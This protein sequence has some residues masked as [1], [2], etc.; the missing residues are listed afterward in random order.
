MHICLV[1]SSLAAG[2]AERVVAT[3][4]STWVGQSDG[5]QVSVVTGDSGNEPAYALASSVKHIALNLQSSSVGILSA[6]RA[7]KYR[8]RALRSALTD[9]KPDCVVAFMDE[10]A[11]LV[12]VASLGTNVP[13]I[14]ALRS[15]PRGPHLNSIWRWMRRPFFQYGCA[16]VVVQTGS[17]YRIAQMLFPRA[18]LYIIPN[19]LPQL[20]QPPPMSER[21]RLVVSVGRLVSTKGLDDL[22]TAFSRS[23]GPMENWRLHIYGEGPERTRLEQQ[24]K[25]L[26]V[27]NAV[28][29]MGTTDKIFDHLAEASVFAFASR[30]E[31]FPNGLFE[32]AAMG[33]ACV[34]T[35]CE[36]GP[37]DILGEHMRGLL[38]PTNDIGALTNAINQLIGNLRLRQDLSQRA[39]ELR[40]THRAETIA[41]RWLR[42][43]Q[44]CAAA[45]EGVY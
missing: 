8:I 7:T 37:R 6:L 3:L 35:D 28:Q 12:S 9:L 30:T 29:L 25:S 13:V 19:P 33:C 21:R 38:V 20:P 23:L 5:I 39:L 15:D 10:M 45:R 17:A 41:A 27:G 34:S 16:A 32:A 42:L 26:G 4:A 22:I 1:I 11:V 14:A 36:F 43:I 2:G 31:G 18:P 44:V 40:D 24:I